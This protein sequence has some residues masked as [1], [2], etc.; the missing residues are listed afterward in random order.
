MHALDQSG[1]LPQNSV[2]RL[3]LGRPVV[4]GR[5]TYESIGKPL[6]D[7]TNIV[8]TRDRAWK[9]EGA[10]AVYSLEEAMAKAREEHPTEI[11]IIGGAELHLATP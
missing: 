11:A 8:I 4:M 5:K 9:A 1:E 10:V 3:T 7:R 2:R 6:K